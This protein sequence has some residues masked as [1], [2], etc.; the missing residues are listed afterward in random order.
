MTTINIQTP[1]LIDLPMPIETDR[2]I[3]RE[4]RFGDGAALHEA[5]ME[6]WDM[7]HRWMPWAKEKSTVLEDEKVMREA[8][9]NFLQR[10]DLMMVATEKETGRFL[11]GTGLHRF[12]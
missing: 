3:L 4:P 9:V 5:K 7:L 10:T 11:G 1:I 2:M 6:T 8:H 12:D